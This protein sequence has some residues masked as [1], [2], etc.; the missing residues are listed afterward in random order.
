VALKILPPQLTQSATHAK[1]LIEEAT[2][3]RKLAHENIVRVYEWAQD[4]ATSSYF[5]IMEYLEGQDLDAYLAEQGTLALDAVIRCCRRWRRAAICVGQAQAGTPR[6]QA[7]QCVPDQARRDQAAGLRH[8][9]A[10]AQRRQQPRFADAERRH[11]RLSRAGGGHASAPAC[12]QAGR[13]CGGGDDLP[14]AGR[15]MPFDDMRPADFH[16]SPPRPE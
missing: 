1:L 5:I 16:P 8:R 15:R 11:R 2:Q 7:G 3:A 12:A 6:H 10:R 13:V 9:F 14:A 4:P